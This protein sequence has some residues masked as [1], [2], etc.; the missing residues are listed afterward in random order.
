MANSLYSYSNWATP[1]WCALD[2]TFEPPTTS[3]DAHYY[4]DT[5]ATSHMTHFNGTLQNYIP[6]KHPHNNAIFVDNGYSIPV[7]GYGYAQPHPSFSLANV[8]HA[9]KLIKNL[10]SVRKFTTNNNVSVEFD[11]FDFSVKALDTGNQIL[12]CNSKSDLYPFILTSVKPPHTSSSNM[13][14]NI[15]STSVWHSRLG[16][17]GRDILVPTC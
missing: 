9:P 12:W 5:R 6:F 8:L 1:Q 15:A 10:I 11:P 2:D 14:F 4:M 7:H 3:P 13:V 17:P 16:H